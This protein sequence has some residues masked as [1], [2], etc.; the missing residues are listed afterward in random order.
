[1]QCFALHINDS[2]RRSSIV[3]TCLINSTVQRLHEQLQQMRDVVR[4][5]IVLSANLLFFSA[6]TN[7]KHSARTSCL[8]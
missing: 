3:G 2:M 8:F 4:R 6:S 1:M 5:N 7:G